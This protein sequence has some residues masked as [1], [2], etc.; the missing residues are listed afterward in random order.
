ME[1]VWKEID[2]ILNYVYLQTDRCCQD[3]C[4]GQ[5]CKHKVERLMELLINFRK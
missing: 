4:E 5:E 3:L 1:D 2:D